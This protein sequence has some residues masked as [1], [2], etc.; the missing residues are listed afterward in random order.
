MGLLVLGLVIF[1]GAHSTRIFADDWRGRQIARIGERPWKGL[2]SVVS[3]VGFAL[4]I[5][6]YGQARNLPGLL[7]LS[8]QWLRHVTALLMLISFVLL[9][10]AYVPRNSIRA[11]LH[12]P[13]LLGVKTWAFAHLL[14][15]GS[16][17]DVLLFGAF[18]VW[19]VVA[20]R[21][22]RRRDRAANTVYA[23]GTARGTAIAVIV[24]IVAWAV[25]GM[26]LHGPLIGV[27]PIA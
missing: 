20:F 17:A 26:W 12:H 27:K 18:L 4:V 19:A 11:R 24:G 13:M 25:F 9:V 3:I 10:A 23:P 14:S 8:P 2:Y 21:A 7:W 1:L 6:G 16:D 22:A 5:W 15:N